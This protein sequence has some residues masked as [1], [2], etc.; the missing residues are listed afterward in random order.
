MLARIDK[1]E[2]QIGELRAKMREIPLEEDV[3]DE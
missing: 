2:K 3:T 1:V